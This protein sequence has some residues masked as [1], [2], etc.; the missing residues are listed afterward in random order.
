MRLTECPPCE[1]GDHK[2]HYRIIHPAPVGGFGG[3]VCDCKGECVEHGPPSLDK[4]LGFAEGTMA[5]AFKRAVV[6]TE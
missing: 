3:A 6:P 4:M 2:H 1:M 5:R